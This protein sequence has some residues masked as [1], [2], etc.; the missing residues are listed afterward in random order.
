MAQNQNELGAMMAAQNELAGINAARQQTSQEEQAF[1]Q[2][3]QAASA[4]MMQ[5]AQIGTS[6]GGLPQQVGAMNPQTQA[7]LAQYGV[8]GAPIPGRTTSSNK[9]TQNGNNIK[10]EN[11]TTTNNDI[12]IIN[13]PSTGGG[14]NEAA[15]NQTKFQ[16]W[17][18]NAFAKQGQDYEV[19]R[20]MFAR[21]DRDLEK[22]SNKMMREIEK[23]NKSLGEKLNPKAWAVEQ[24]GEMKKVLTILL[25]T[26]APTLVKPIVDGIKNLKN[27]FTGG[28]EG[29][30][31]VSR[32]KTAIGLDDEKTSLS[33][34]IG[35]TISDGIKGVKDW[36][37]L[38]FEER[39]RAI[40]SLEKPKARL[41]IGDKNASILWRLGD[42]M[43]Y[44]SNVVSAGLGG[45]S[46]LSKANAEQMRDDSQKKFTTSNEKAATMESGVHDLLHEGLHHQQ[47]ISKDYYDLTGRLKGGDSLAAMAVTRG[48]SAEIKV[49]SIRGPH[50]KPVDSSII[51]KRMSDLEI[52]LEKEGSYIIGEKPDVLNFLDVW[53]LDEK[54]FDLLLKEKLI[55]PKDLLYITYKISKNR[56]DAG[57]FEKDKFPNSFDQKNI[58]DVE[59][60]IYYIMTKGGF[61][62]IKKDV[63]GNKDFE[64][65]DSKNDSIVYNKLTSIHSDQTFKN[66]DRFQQLAN[67]NSVSAAYSEARSDVSFGQAA[68]VAKVISNQAK[69]TGGAVKGFVSSA[70][71]SIKGATLKGAYL[72]TNAGRQNFIEDLY[73]VFSKELFSFYKS[74][75]LSDEEAQERASLMASILTSQ[76]ALESGY[77]TNSNSKYFNYA[78]LTGGKNTR[79]GKDKDKNGDEIEQNFRVF[80]SG[81]EFAQALIHLLDSGKQYEGALFADS[82]EDYFKM[83]QRGYDGIYNPNKLGAD[84]GKFAEDKE[85]VSKGL[86][87]AEKVIPT[88]EEYAKSLLAGDN[89]GEAASIKFD[90]SVPHYI[91]PDKQYK[92]EFDRL[93]IGN[94]KEGETPWDAMIGLYQYNS[95]TG[96]YDIPVDKNIFNISD[97]NS[98]KD[99][100]NRGVSSNQ[101]KELYKLMFDNIGPKDGIL[102]YRQPRKNFSDLARLK[103]AET[104][105]LL[106]KSDNHEDYINIPFYLI[107]TKDGKLF[108]INTI[109]VRTMNYSD[110]VDCPRYTGFVYEQFSGRYPDEYYKLSDATIAGLP[111]GRNP[112][113][114][115]IGFELDEKGN[116]A[117]RNWKGIL[118]SGFYV[119]KNGYLVFKNETYAGSG[120]YEEKYLNRSEV[121]GL[122][123][124]GLITNV[125]KHFL[126]IG[127]HNYSAE[128]TESG[129]EFQ[130]IVSNDEK[131]DLGWHGKYKYLSGKDWEAMN[132]DEKRKYINFLSSLTTD[133]QKQNALKLIPLN[134]E[135]ALEQAQR[136]VGVITPQNYSAITKIVEPTTKT[137]AEK[138]TE[139]TKEGTPIVIN[140]GGSSVYN[141]NKVY[142]V[143]YGGVNPSDS[144]S[145]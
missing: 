100:I 74:K 32:I 1:L 130:D 31:F 131:I 34:A 127:N 139:N 119:N 69:A 107:P 10:V 55:Y 65:K 96:L 91:T 71:Q 137:G 16:V 106:G 85:Y 138:I 66:K 11:N 60:R 90:G 144:T 48:I 112:Q 109:S 82:A 120:E 123:K 4:V 29:E 76:C 42:W 89:S 54:Y 44:L 84:N 3:Q 51:G 70:W 129:K 77:G 135:N 58:I 87:I 122:E 15:A 86:K 143:Y 2:Q 52:L 26:V 67:T 99:V 23:S 35:K 78:N 6:G 5:A 68:E 17:L 9:T 141:D 30:S 73:G 81:E 94:L 20:R 22:Q 41:K 140:E 8:T 132:D 46:G 19:Q 121:E 33:E 7:L 116:E 24:G 56:I 79:K 25:L 37:G 80:E 124:L 97:P 111:S 88:I 142:H 14:G 83:I 103:I 27:F 64:F 125:K 18:S 43:V 75:G 38:L 40:E 102:F 105:D 92:A 98:L 59:K 39:R 114:Y 110:T 126:G 28:T 134:S 13:P 21:R 57:L 45:F 145:S 115:S 36:F 133:S 62:R 12:K 47:T 113:F 118:G 49:N 128:L 136:L 101:Y 72:N 50:Q 108:Q 53:G 95:K 104:A 117:L 63:F 61:D 93:R